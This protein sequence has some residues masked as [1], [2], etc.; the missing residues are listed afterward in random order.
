MVEHIVIVFL[1]I[2]TLIAIAISLIMCSYLSG[3]VV[4]GSAGSL[5]SGTQGTFLA[6]FVFLVIGVIGLM[7]VLLSLVLNAFSLYDNA[8]QK[9]EGVPVSNSAFESEA[10]VLQI[11]HPHWYAFGLWM[12]FF[13]LLALVMYII[14]VAIQ[15]TSYTAGQFVLIVIV[16]ACI[17]FA[18][19]FV[20]VWVSAEGCGHILAICKIVCCE[21]CDSCWTCGFRHS[22]A[23]SVKAKTK[24]VATSSSSSRVVVP[25]LPNSV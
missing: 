24:Q 20:A 10:R 7:L 18:V 9:Y 3:D 23:D 22:Y 25:P 15:F 2:G 17:G 8:A 1:Q 19:L 6:A 16:A 12:I 21:G 4:E 13:V 11:E 14:V 5:E